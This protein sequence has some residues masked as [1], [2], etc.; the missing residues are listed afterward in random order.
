MITALGCGRIEPTS[1][2]KLDS[3]DAIP[4]LQTIGK[5]VAEQKVD[6]AHFN[7]GVFKP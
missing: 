1:V 3:I 5:A 4:D 2:Q 6:R 7:F